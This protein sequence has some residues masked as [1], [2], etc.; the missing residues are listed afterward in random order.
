M[1]NGP[2]HYAI[3]V[4]SYLINALQQL[5]MSQLSEQQR[6]QVRTMAR[7]HAVTSIIFSA[8]TLEAFCNYCIAELLGSLGATHQE[9]VIEQLASHF[10]NLR[11][12]EKWKQLFKHRD[13]HFLAAID[14]DWQLYLELIEVRNQLV[15]SRPARTTPSFNP[16]ESLG[17]KDAHQALSIVNNMMTHGTRLFHGLVPSEVYSATTFEPILTRAYPEERVPLSRF[18][19]EPFRVTELGVPPFRA[20]GPRIYRET[21]GMEDLVPPDNF[22]MLEVQPLFFSSANN[23]GIGS[24]RVVGYT[25]DENSFV[26]P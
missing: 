21:L 25:W 18:L 7:E 16:V 26:Q 14:K 15:H 8:M 3:F 17:S 23:E 19:A 5:R 9:V 10:R 1:S 20:F 11:I 4:L 24:I 12:K 13:G 2:Q 6:G 22:P